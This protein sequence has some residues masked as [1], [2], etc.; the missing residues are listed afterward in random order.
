MRQSLECGGHEF[1]TETLAPGVR[2]QVDGTDLADLT[3]VRVI[4]AGRADVCKPAEFVAVG[5]DQ[6]S[7]A[8]PVDNRK[9]LLAAV[10]PVCRVQRVEE[11]LR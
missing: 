4:V 9:G 6:D 2:R 5:R 1:A 8:M 3:F 7:A 10:E 11:I